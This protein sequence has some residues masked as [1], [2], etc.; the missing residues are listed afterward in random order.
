MKSVGQIL[1][2]ARILAKLEI[3]DVSRITKI[4]PSYLRLIEADNYSQLPDGAT[5]RGFIRN[6]CEFL[7]L[8]PD[9]ILAIFRRDFVE[10][11]R[12][13]IV[14]RGIAEPV[15]PTNLWTPKT[16][17]MAIVLFV[18][19]LFGIYLF[20]QYRL[21]VGPPEL[22]ITQPATDIVISDPSQEIVGQTNPEATISVNGQLIALDKG[23]LFSVRFPLQSG[24]NK[25]IITATG[26]SG[27]KI[28]ITRIV[29]LTSS[30]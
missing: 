30:P 14:P 20:Y 25:F 28:S 12:G 4:R 19:L 18:F 27:R 8:S 13:Q 7:S 26:K 10:N 23:G 16:T 21:L 29:T 11:R 1:T 15:N 3:D 22:K 2:E 9:R 24:Q 6:Y 17:I 5:A